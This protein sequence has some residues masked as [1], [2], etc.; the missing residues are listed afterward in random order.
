MTACLANK[1]E[2]MK[3]VLQDSVAIYQIHKTFKRDVR[4]LISNFLTH[5][6]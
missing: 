1:D 3:Y 2:I 4:R 5:Q 6:S